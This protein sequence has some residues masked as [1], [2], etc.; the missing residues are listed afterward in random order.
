MREIE[1]VDITIAD[2]RYVIVYYYHE[3]KREI[4]VTLEDALRRVEEL[5]S[6]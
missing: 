5:L 4:F 2:N 3:I 6:D 1:K